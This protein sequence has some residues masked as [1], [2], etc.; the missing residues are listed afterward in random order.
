VVERVKGQFAAAAFVWRRAKAVYAVED[1]GHNAVIVY[2]EPGA[3]PQIIVP[4]RDMMSVWPVTG[5]VLP[6][7]VTHFVTI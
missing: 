6:G 5:G 7:P 4:G 2:R 3:T 1:T